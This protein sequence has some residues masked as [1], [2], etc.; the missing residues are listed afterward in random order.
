MKTLRLISLT[1]LIL[2]MAGNVTGQDVTQPSSPLLD[3][4]TVDPLTGYATLHWLPSTSTDVGSY[5]VYTVSNN[6][7]YAVD[8]LF[9]PYIT[10]YIHTGS[11]ARYMS[12]T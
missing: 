7:A 6:I 9:S 1:L 2:F 3:I 11:A 8:T 4:V 10:D 12:V 5:I